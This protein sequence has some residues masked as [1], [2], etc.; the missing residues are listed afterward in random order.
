MEFI[1]VLGEFDCFFLV[2]MGFGPFFCVLVVV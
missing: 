1:E 2:G